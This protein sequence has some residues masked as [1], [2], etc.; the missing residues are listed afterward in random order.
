YDQKQDVEQGDRHARLFQALREL[1]LARPLV[2]VGRRIQ[3]Q[4]ESKATLSQPVLSAH[5]RGVNIGSKALS[6]KCLKAGSF[7]PPAGSVPVDLARALYSG[8]SPSRHPSFR[9]GSETGWGFPSAAM[10]ATRPES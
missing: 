9:R 6:L 5:G 4:D 2:T 10:S 1:A 8:A 7:R 3:R